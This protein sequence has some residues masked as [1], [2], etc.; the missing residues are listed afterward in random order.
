[1]F[2]PS[3]VLSAK[4]LIVDDQAVNVRLLELMLGGAGYTAVT[5]TLAPHEVCELHRRNR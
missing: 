3:D 4:V 5:S 2:E 1:M